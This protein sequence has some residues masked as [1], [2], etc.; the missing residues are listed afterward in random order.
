MSIKRLFLLAVVVISAVVLL[1]RLAWR[2]TLELLGLQEKAGI[3]VTSSPEAAVFINGR[4]VGKTPYQNNDLG[5]GE[6]QIKLVEGDARWGGKVSL[7]SGTLSAVNRELAVDI[8]SSSGEVL[9]LTPGS[10]I[11]IS[12]T[13]GQADVTIDGKPYGRTPLIAADVPAGEH[14]FILSH[15]NYTDRSIR[16]IVPDKLTLNIAVDLALA[17][18]DLGVVALPSIA[19]LPKVIILQT[20]TGFLRVRDKPSLAGNEI[21]RVPSG[22]SLVLLE[23]TVGWD[24]VKLKDGTEGYISASYTQKQP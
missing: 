12:S 15:G 22:E 20:P 18:A 23:E 13:P 24:R 16:A 19:P 6:Y 21:S 8:A 5:V 3:K 17:E 11:L 9:T 10:G 2:P 4:E 7:N 1:A 14:T